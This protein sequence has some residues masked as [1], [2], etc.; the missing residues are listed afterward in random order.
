[1]HHMK[2][3]MPT[4]HQLAVA[5]SHVVGIAGSSIATLAFTG[6]LNPQQAADA[7][8]AIQHISS[9]IVDLIGSVGTLIAIGATVWTTLRSGPLAS[10]FRAAATISQS[11]ALTAEVNQAS[12]LQK[13]PVV[14]ITDKMPEVAGVGTTATPAGAEMALSVPS[15]T[16][17]QVTGKSALG[18]VAK[19]LVIGL[20]LASLMVTGSAHA[21]TRK[22]APPA[23]TGDL[24]KDLN[25]DAQ[26]LGLI[27]KSLVVTPTGNIAADLQTLWSK[28]IGAADTDLAY[29]SKMAASAATPASAVRKQC[30]DAIIVVNMQANGQN[31][32][33]ANGAVLTKPDPHV[34]TDVESLAEVVDNLSPSGPLFTA[35]AGAAQLAKTNVLT[36]INAVVT[37]AAG[38]AAMPIIPGL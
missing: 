24:K 38:M 26:N 33:D 2:I 15:Q 31:L 36:F 20:A 35:C 13:A 4:G 21:Q 19:A 25:T 6:A 1:M 30:W 7:T 16:V 12:I 8:H 27:P 10:L 17:Q 9:D 5:G 22:L 3:T 18:S 29:A 14:A 28:I 32:K 23:V 37:G 34:F 11:P